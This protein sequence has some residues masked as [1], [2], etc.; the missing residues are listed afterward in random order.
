[1]ID[2]GIQENLIETILTKSPKEREVEAVAHQ[3]LLHQV[4]VEVQVAAV[5]E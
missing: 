3:V 5:I 4:A 2:K 1:M